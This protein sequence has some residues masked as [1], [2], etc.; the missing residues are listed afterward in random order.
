ML[1]L[2]VDDS[3]VLVTVQGWQLTD[4]LHFFFLTQ[5]GYPVYLDLS[6]A[7]I[8]GQCVTLALSW[9]L[10]LTYTDEVYI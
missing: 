7:D 2:P 8:Q 4:E 10:R 9:C 5:V 1:A 3:S 6:V